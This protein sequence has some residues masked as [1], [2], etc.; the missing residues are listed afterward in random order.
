ME[1]DGE[2]VVT[3]NVRPISL[4]LKGTCP[5]GEVFSNVIW[6]D[7]EFELAASSKE[8]SLAN[9]IHQTVR[10]G[11]WGLPVWVDIM[12]ILQEHLE[13]LTPRSMTK[14]GSTRGK[15]GDPATVRFT[16]S[17]VFSGDFGLLTSSGFPS[18][19]PTQGRLDG[20]RELLLR[21]FG[22]GLTEDTLSTDDD[23]VDPDEDGGDEDDGGDEGDG[24]TKPEKWPG[25]IVK[26]PREKP[27]QQEVDEKDRRRAADFLGKVVNK[28]SEKEYLETRPP[29]LMAKDLAIIAI[30]MT[31][32]QAEN[33]LSWEEYFGATHK[34][35]RRALFNDSETVLGP[36]DRPAGYVEKLYR[37][38]EDPEDFAERFATVDLAAALAT[39]ALATQR[40][41]LGPEQALLALAQVSAVARMPWLWRTDALED[42]QKQIRQLLVHTGLV[43]VN[44]NEAWTQYCENWDKLIKRGYAI[45][46]FQEAFEDLELGKLREIVSRNEVQQG[47]LLWQGRVGICVL[48]EGCRRDLE[49]N[50]PVLCLQSREPRKI[51]KSNFIVPVKDLLD[52]IEGK[53]VS[54]LPEEAHTV[55]RDFMQTL[56]STLEGVEAAD[57]EDLPQQLS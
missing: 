50:V 10:E 52:S 43:G 6:V 27:S 15:D 18:W 36:G 45:R 35:W 19:A 37:K 7:Q 41:L 33:W 28:I 13:Y 34:I 22:F 17:D 14:G 38:W 23:G 56:T 57:I 3:P 29:E 39:W 55:L 32:A 24:G 4:Q 31:S 11:I 2:L 12:K 40:R 1:S 26:G 16:R 8:R 5:A 42:L 21:W 47:E 54:G 30:L 9:T 20:L 49:K 46:A 25:T 51:F 44:D 53:E 48:E